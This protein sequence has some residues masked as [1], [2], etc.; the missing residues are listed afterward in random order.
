M[1]SIYSGHQQKG[2]VAESWVDARRHG[3]NASLVVWAVS[4]SVHVATDTGAPQSR[5]E[6][7]TSIATTPCQA[8][9]VGF[10]KNL[11]FAYQ[12]GAS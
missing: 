2:E 6:R 3:R 10:L 11:L 12:T 8:L 7:I 4:A 9:H 1:T 5:L